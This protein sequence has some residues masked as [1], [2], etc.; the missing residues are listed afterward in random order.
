V[1]P[2]GSVISTELWSARRNRAA[3]GSVSKAMCIDCAAG[4]HAP[5]RLAGHEVRHALHGKAAGRPAHRSGRSCLGLLGRS[6]PLEFD[7]PCSILRNRASK[8]LK[9]DNGASKRPPLASPHEKPRPARRLRIFL[10]LLGIEVMRENKIG[11][12]HCQSWTRGKGME[13]QPRE[14]ELKCPMFGLRR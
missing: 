8:S 4:H 11:L 10:L 7:S 1:K 3:T 5:W 12:Q 6:P 9:L 14:K 2:P 13:S